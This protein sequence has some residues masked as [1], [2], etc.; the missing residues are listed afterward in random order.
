MPMIETERQHKEIVPF[1]CR[2]GVT[3]KR[4][5]FADKQLRRGKEVA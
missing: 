1:L 5:F 3:R 2:E 4:L